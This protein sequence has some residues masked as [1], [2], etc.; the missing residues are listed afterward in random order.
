MPHAAVLDSA[1]TPAV[2]DRASWQARLD[3]LLIREKAHTREGDAIAAERRRLPMVEV[4]A[5]IP[6]IGADGPVPLL[7]TFE[8]RR[9]LLAYFHMWYDGR[10]PEGQCEGCTFFN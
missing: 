3:D 4:D 2:V 9:Q 7:E 8:G 10:P 5:S 1:P 6:V